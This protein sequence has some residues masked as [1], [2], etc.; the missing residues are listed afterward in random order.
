MIRCGHPPKKCYMDKDHQ[1]LCEKC[2]EPLLQNDDKI[3][4]NPFA[5]GLISK[6]E[7]ACKNVLYDPSKANEEKKEEPKQCEWKGLV[8]DWQKHNDTDCQYAIIN[9]ND[10]CEYQSSRSLQAAHHDKC[11]FAVIKCPLNCNGDILRKDTK[12]H[13]EQKCPKTVMKCTNAECNEEPL[14]EVLNQHVT[15]LCPKRLVD[16]DYGQYGCTQARVKHESMADHMQQ[17][18]TKHIQ[19]QLNR[20]YQIVIQVV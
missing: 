4:E 16:C 8:K 19:F 10:C 1:T 9:C 14:R 5:D 17:F 20:L 7:I 3:T 11:D 13:T 12:D 2:R 6:A 18:E 15:Q